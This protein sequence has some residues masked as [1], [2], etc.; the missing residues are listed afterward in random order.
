MKDQ[1]LLLAQ[2]SVVFLEVRKLIFK[3]IPAKYSFE[4]L[5]F[6]QS[7]FL[8]KVVFHENVAKS[9]C[10]S[11]TLM[12]FL[13]TII[14]LLY[15]KVFYSFFHFITESFEGTCIQGPGFSKI[16]NFY[17]FNSDIK[18]NWLLF[19]KVP[20]YGYEKHSDTGAVWGLLFVSICARIPPVS[21]AIV[22]ALAKV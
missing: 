22:F 12:P 14:I 10:L 3:V 6:F 16:N 8:V 21:S 9:P 15:A 4:L 20:V 13:K 11:L 7:H 17:C 2:N 1:I 5:Q 18:K 19:F